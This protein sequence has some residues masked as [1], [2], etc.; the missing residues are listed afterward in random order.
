MLLKEGGVPM[1]AAG[2]QASSMQQS[3][4]HAQELSLPVLYNTS[5]H[6]EEHMKY[7]S[8]VL[9][10]MAGLIK[11]RTSCGTRTQDSNVEPIEQHDEPIDFDMGD[12]EAVSLA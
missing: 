5:K 10:R 8:S 12:Q 7:N 2:Y 4:E 3:N 1:I 9:K 6:N 11:R